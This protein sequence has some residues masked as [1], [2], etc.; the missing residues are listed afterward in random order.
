M[1]RIHVD[2]RRKGMS[3][4]EYLH[5]TEDVFVAGQ[6]LL[7][8]REDMHSHSYLSYISAILADSEVHVIW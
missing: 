5:T 3:E 2:K 7:L 1:N 8:Y 6:V 4:N